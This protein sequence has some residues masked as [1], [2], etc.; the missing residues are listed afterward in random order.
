MKP[1]LCWNKGLREVQLLAEV[2]KNIYVRWCKLILSCFHLGLQTFEAPFCKALQFYLPTTFHLIHLPC[3]P[4]FSSLT[5][6]PPNCSWKLTPEGFSG[7]GIP[8]GA[9]PLLSRGIAT[10]WMCYFI[11][12]YAQPCFSSS[13]TASWLLISYFLLYSKDKCFGSF[14]TISIL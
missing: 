2:K 9:I 14:V 1:T 4:I 8:A 5:A 13:I 3:A 10:P 7:K 6:I 12:I 11:H